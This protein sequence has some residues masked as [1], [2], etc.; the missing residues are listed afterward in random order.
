[1]GDFGFWGNWDSLECLPCLLEP[2]FQANAFNL[3]SLRH[4]IEQVFELGDLTGIEGVF[5]VVHII[6]KLSLMT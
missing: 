1:M 3:I 2:V 5:L 6:P 4:D